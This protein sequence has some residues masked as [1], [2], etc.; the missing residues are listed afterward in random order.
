M[1]IAVALLPDAGAPQVGIAVTGLDPSAASVITVEVTWDGTV[2]HGVRGAQRL[3]VLGSVFLRDYVPPL[4]VQATYRLT[5]LS[6]AVVPT[7]TTAAIV[8]PSTSA[9]L[10][11]P[12]NP[13]RAV[14]VLA[15]GMADGSATLTLGSLAVATWDQHV[16]L[17]APQ[18]AAL[19]VA[20]ISR[21]MLAGDVPLVLSHDVAVA[22]T[23]VRDLL[24][25]AGAV[26]LR[27]LPVANLLEPVA[28]VAVGAAQ[29]SRLGSLSQVSTWTLSVRQVRPTSMAVA[30]PWWTYDQVRSLWVGQTYDQAKAARPGATYLD[31]QRD[32][33]RP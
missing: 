22:A 5:V 15:T 13:R 4:N 18:G 7:P 20:S 28:H 12:L 24:L 10:Q 31:W 2:W 21:R 19:P 30:V 17:A 3:S 8:V 33:T 32:P 6:G 23:A 1:G 16:D 11:D 29:E 26:V 27:G 25:G 14:A 9:W